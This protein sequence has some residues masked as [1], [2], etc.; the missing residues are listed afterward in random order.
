MDKKE[1]KKRVILQPVHFQV[2]DFIKSSLQ[3]NYFA[4]TNKEIGDE[5]QL[6]TRHLYRVLSDLTTLGCIDRKPRVERSIEILDDLYEVAKRSN[7]A[8]NS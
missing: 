7:K 3:K 1:S 2:F 4:P 5:T 8:F 6:S